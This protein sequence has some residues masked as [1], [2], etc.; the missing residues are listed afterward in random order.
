MTVNGFSRLGLL[1]ALT[2]LVFLSECWAQVPTT[3]PKPKNVPVAS[4]W[5]GGLDGGAFVLVTHCAKC[6]RGIYRA[7]IHGQSGWLWYKGLL[8]INRLDGPDFDLSSKM[9]YDSWDGTR[10][11]YTMTDI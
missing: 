9:S 4:I 2:G 8:K 7:E 11:F 10:L 6:S 1:I 3:P 5:V